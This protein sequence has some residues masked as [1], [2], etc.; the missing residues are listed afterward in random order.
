MVSLYLGSI[1]LLALCDGRLG[2]DAVA[3]ECL[4]RVKLLKHLGAVV[5]G[6]DAV[7]AAEEVKRPGEVV[8]FLKQCEAEEDSRERDRVRP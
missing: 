7:K 1:Y 2:A 5:K 8:E 4:D 3:D 6:S